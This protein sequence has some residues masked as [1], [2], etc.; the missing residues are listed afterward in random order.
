MIQPFNETS[1]SALADFMLSVER[2]TLN[3][4]RFVIASNGKHANE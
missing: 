2:W 1:G 3:V 4:E